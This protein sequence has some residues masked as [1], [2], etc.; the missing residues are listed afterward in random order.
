M[1]DFVV[2]SCRVIPLSRLP[3]VVKLAVGRL[4]DKTAIVRK[5]SITLMHTLLAM[6]P[7]GPELDSDQFKHKLKLAGEQFKEMFGEQAKR[8]CDATTTGIGSQQNAGP[9]FLCYAIVN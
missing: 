2:C 8:M 4:D 5:N 9:N 3:D 7:F 1:I 6:N